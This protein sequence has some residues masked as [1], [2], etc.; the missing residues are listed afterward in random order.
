M[1][2]DFGEN[3]LLKCVSQLEIAK[4]SLKFAIFRL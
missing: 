3:S 1:S 2:S 4:N